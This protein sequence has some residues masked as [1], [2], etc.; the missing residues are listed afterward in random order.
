MGLFQEW[1]QYRLDRLRLQ[2]D[3]Q[4]KPFAMAE[5]LAASLVSAMNSQTQVLQDWMGAFKTTEIPKTSTVRSEDEYKDEMERERK[6]EWQALEA[7]SGLFNSIRN[8]AK[9]GVF[10]EASDLLRMNDNERE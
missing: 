4:N 5:N 10:P 3:A 7:N 1:K 6:D 2:L 9:A 8:A